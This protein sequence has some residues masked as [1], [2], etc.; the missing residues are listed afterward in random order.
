MVAA[1]S[2]VLLAV[3]PAAAAAPQLPP[4][5]A[6]TCA[7]CLVVAG[8]D[9]IWGREIDSRRANASTTKMVTALVAAR[10]GRLQETVVASRAASATGG[11]GLD[12]RPGDRF[13]VE[14][15]LVAMLL[16]S[17]NDAA[18]A[19]A[20][21]V[22]GSEKA[23]VA[24]MNALARDLGAR[25]SR[26][27]TPHG[28]D[29][30]G[31]YSSAR[32]L[33]RIALAIL[34]SP[35]LSEIVATRSASIT[36]RGRR[37]RLVN[38]NPLL[39]SYPGAVGIKTGYTSGAGDVLVAAA[40]RSGR[41]LVAVAMGSDDAAADAAA[42][43]DYGFRALGRGVLLRAGA[44]LGVVV[45]DPSGSVGV[46]AGRTVHGIQR[47]ETISIAFEPGTAAPPLAEGETLGTVVITASDGTLVA[48]APAVAE[49]AI[50]D[51]DPGGVA[52]LLGDVLG[53]AAALIGG[54]SW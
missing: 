52:S 31:H 32:D 6:V 26:F 13:T 16:T 40:A 36:G 4:R 39:D 9:V 50:A 8:E 38:T 46:V 30:P 7:A 19:L 22:A 54:R 35:A 44:E 33:A 37:I 24:R 21:H 34:R 47:P 23:F 51:A 49:Q 18:V 48:R 41:R 28:L 1:A 43:L 5:P 53:A 2:A 45:F 17:S 3:A 29:A 10:Q 20:E 14:E 27:V 12:L 15:L 25:N 42:L 11:G